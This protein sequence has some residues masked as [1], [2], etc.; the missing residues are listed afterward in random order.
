MLRLLRIR[1]FALFTELEIEFGEGLNLLTG[2][3]GSGKSILVDAFGLILGDRSSQEMIRHNTESAVIEGLFEISPDDGVCKVLSDAGFEN[4]ENILLIRREVSLTGKNRI[5]INGHLATLNLLKTIGENLADIHGQQDQKSLLDLSTHL[6][7]L[8]YFGN[9]ANFLHEVHSR[10]RSM[11]E[12]ARLLE[13]YESDKQERMR[14]MEILGF[15]LEEIESIHPLPDEIEELQKERTIL[16]NSEKIT[17]LA[18][19]VYASLY[20]SDSSI[21]MRMR[22][23]EHV[24]QELDRFDESWNAHLESLKE[25]LYK[26]EDIALFS[27]DYAS[28]YDF[29][30]ARLEEVQNRLFSL[31]KLVKKYCCADKDLLEFAEECRRE[32]QALQ[33]SSDSAETLLH[34]LQTEIAQYSESATQLSKKRRQDALILEKA[35]KKEFAALAMPAMDM[36][37]E[38]HIVKNNSGNAHVPSSYGLDGMDRVEFFIA[39]NKGEEMKPLAKIASGGEL[40]RLMLAVKSLCGKEETGKSLVFDEVDAGIGGRVAETVGKRLRTLSRDTQVF[41]VTHLPQVAAFAQNHFIVEKHEK[42]NRTETIVKQLNPD[43]R[44]Q[45]ISRMLGGEIITE[46]TRRHAVEML[47]RSD[48]YLEGC[49]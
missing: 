36:K 44:I 48:E 45:E 15:Q 5:F 30:P 34:R 33:S 46:T 47:Q 31:E 26:L 24:M 39:P 3:T 9:N 42:D 16:S 49:R 20:E 12:T 13:R 37:V 10:F 7:W 19:D 27:R 18:T 11:W 14:H 38:F 28:R 41:C 29:N 43:E 17:E 2:E 1:N 6:K 40:S 25:C 21:L 23:L 8:D 4:E 32:L 22:K 35:I